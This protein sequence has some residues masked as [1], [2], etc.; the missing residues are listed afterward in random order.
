MKRY[1]VGG[2]I[3]DELLGLPVK[4]RDW[5]VVGA[6]PEEMAAAGYTPVGKDFPVFLHPQTREEHALARTERKSGLGYHGFTFHTGADVTI[7]QDLSRRDLTVNAIAQDEDGRRVDPY[8]GRRDLE[9]RVLR[10]VSPAFAEDPVRI[11]RLARF[12]ARFAPLGFAVAPDTLALMR[13]MVAAGE[14]DA[15]VAERVWQETA[16]ALA[17]ERPSVYF[18]TLRECGA[19]ARVMPELDALFG[20]P[21]RADYHPEVDSGVHTMMCVEAAVRMGFALPV[22]VSALLHDL[23][24]AKTPRAEWPSHKQ[25]ERRGVPL[26]E[27]FCERLRVP[28]DCRDLAVIH[29]REHL[30]IHQALELRPETLA[31]L[32][33]RVDAARRPERFA[34]LLEACLCDARGRTGYENCEYPPVPYLREAARVMLEVQAGDLASSGLTGAAIGQE[35]RRRRIEK[36][37]AWVASQRQQ[38]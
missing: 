31:E 1:C 34:Q 25:H 35:L 15:L 29:T 8:G 26:V 10:H 38:Q 13:S 2:A 17:T 28:A 37:G 24:K 5:V 4:E 27:Q 9:A 11:L 32:L 7:E 23:G 19:L 22:R 21:Q 36:L 20:V 33:E 3:R 14:A 6:T 30:I 18:T 16:K 12:H